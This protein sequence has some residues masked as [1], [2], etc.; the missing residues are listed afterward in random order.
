MDSIVINGQM[1]QKMSTLIG[2]IRFIIRIFFKIITISG[3]SSYNSKSP[4]I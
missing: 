3:F 4:I 2:L 1:I